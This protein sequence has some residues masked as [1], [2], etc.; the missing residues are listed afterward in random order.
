MSISIG[1]HSRNKGRPYPRA[2][3]YVTSFLNLPNFSE[4]GTTE[5]L[6][7]DHDGRSLV[8]NKSDVLQKML[9]L[10]DKI[11]GNFMSCEFL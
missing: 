6:T 3:R 2:R 10:V 8:S 11:H 1:R 4:L 5:S 7:S 9:D